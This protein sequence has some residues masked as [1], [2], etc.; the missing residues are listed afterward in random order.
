[1]WPLGSG[2][3]FVIE[4]KE[5]ATPVLLKKNYHNSRH[6]SDVDIFK[7]TF[8]KIKAKSMRSFY[9]SDASL[10]TKRHTNIYFNKQRWKACSDERKFCIEMKGNRG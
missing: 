6:T 7:A 5:E 10:R 3:F 8:E 1:M 4:S 9:L 2:S